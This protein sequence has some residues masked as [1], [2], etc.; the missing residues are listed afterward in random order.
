MKLK[1]TVISAMICSSLISALTLAAEKADS[2]GRGDENQSPRCVSCLRNCRYL[3]NAG[4]TPRLQ[5]EVGLQVWR[6]KGPAAG[7]LTGIL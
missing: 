5:R 1:H 2:V 3:A 7:K 4:Q 6:Q